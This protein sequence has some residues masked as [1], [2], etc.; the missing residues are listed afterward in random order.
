[1][2]VFLL[3]CLRFNKLLEILPSVWCN[4]SNLLNAN[5]PAE[6]KHRVLLAQQEEEDWSVAESQ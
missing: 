6:N 4:F 1:V 5:N 2:L 3:D